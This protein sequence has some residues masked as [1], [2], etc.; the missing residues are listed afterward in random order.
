MAD[1]RLDT[2]VKTW[3]QAQA[4]GRDIPVDELCRDAP[5]LLPAAA[6]AIAALAGETVARPTPRPDEPPYPAESAET[7]SRPTPAWAR[8]TDDAAAETVG[9]PTPAAGPPETLPRP[10]ADPAGGVTPPPGYELEAEVGRGGMGVV[11]KA[12]DVRLNRTVAL[13]MVLGGRPSQQD[14]ARFRVEAEAVAAIDHPHV[15]RVFGCGEADGRPYLAMEYLDGGSLAARLKAA[16]GRLPPA[17]AARVVEQVARGVQAA[18]ALGIVHRDLKPGNILLSSAECGV[19]S[20][21]SKA[22]A[23]GLDSALRTPHSALPKVADFGLARRGTDPGLTQT[24]AVMGTPAY[25]APE[26]AKGDARFVG[27]PADVWA[28]GA[29]LYELLAGQP[30]FPGSDP[31]SILHRAAEEQ[32]TPPRRHAPAVPRDLER[33]CLKCLEKDPRERYATAAALADDLARWR[34]G[35]TISVRPAGPVERAAKWARRRPTAAAA[36]ALGLLA[37]FLTAFAGAAT[38]LWRDA[39]AARERLADEQRITDHA[40]GRERVARVAEATARQEAESAAGRERA[41]LGRLAAAQYARTVD[42]AHREY[43]AND[44]RRARRLLDDCPPDRRGWEWDYVHRLLLPEGRVFDPRAGFAYAV[45]WDPAGKRLVTAHRDKTARVWDAEAGTPGPVLAHADQV[46]DV[47]FTPDGKQV[48][49]AG[50]DGLVQVWDAT[51]GAGVMTLAPPADDPAAKRPPLYAVAVTPDGKAVSAGGAAGLFLTWR[52]DTQENRAAQ[53]VGVGEVTAVKYSPDGVWAAAAG[54]GGRVKVWKRASTVAPTTLTAAGGVLALAFAPDGRLAAGTA[55]GL[56]QVWDPE[57]GR[58]GVA[59]Q[60]HA[61]GVTGVAFTPDGAKLVTAG[62]DRAVGAWEATTGRP[63]LT[64]KGHVDAVWGVAAAPDNRRAAS[65]GLDGTAR[66]WDLGGSPEW[67]A[68]AAAGSEITCLVPAADGRVF[69]GAKSGKVVTIDGRFGQVVTVS[70]PSDRGPDSPEVVALAVEGQAV[71]WVDAGGAFRVG[72]AAGAKTAGPVVPYAMFIEDA[73]ARRRVAAGFGPGGRVAA[74]TADGRVAVRPTPDAKPGWEFAAF[75]EPVSA[76]GFSPDGTKLVVASR[77]NDKPG[78][79]VGAAVWD[80]AGRKKVADLA[81]H[82]GGVF[83]AAFGPDGA[84][85]ATASA[86]FTARLWDAATGQE[87][88]ALRGHLFW[89]RA[90]CWSPDGKRVATG[91]ADGTAKVWDPAT[92]AE[93]LTLPAPGGAATAVAFSA[94]GRTLFVGGAD[95]TVRAFD[96]GPPAGHHAARR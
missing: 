57:T 8:E 33:I 88:H 14:L 65:V 90:V 29:I 86:D 66:V 39:D 94:D 51:T 46:L 78:D 95:G 63:L 53:D 83:A 6:D 62:K 91:S 35:E 87:R 5:D 48:V 45:A 30:P 41:A 7:V 32:P 85:V 69:V 55:D 11:W 54:K 68:F 56:V 50:K 18:H 74:G 25:M 73:L 61:P 93:L 49:T 43:G 58:A 13:K 12:R 47:A 21:E 44:L 4:Q 80:V 15:V 75:P 79:P 3:R 31:W 92:G 40:L 22:G 17:D 77:G 24:G 89:V 59:F 84:A 82:T 37:A 38:L 27:P 64:L 67:R 16:G 36:W 23:S 76:A 19:R 42:L 72:S 60:A 1:D 52:L 10:P 20:A 81:G 2:L 70:D 28:L 26:Q 96:A 34:A 9:R 71:R